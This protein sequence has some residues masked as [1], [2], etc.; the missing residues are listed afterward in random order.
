MISFSD[1]AT[2]RNNFNYARYIMNYQLRLLLKYPSI[3]YVDHHKVKE[4]HLFL[5]T[6]GRAQFDPTKENYVCPN[7][8]LLPP[9]EFADTVAKSSADMFYKFL[10]MN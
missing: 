9:E 3:L 1:F 2:V 7:D 6:L 5:H 8:F 4:K 10:K